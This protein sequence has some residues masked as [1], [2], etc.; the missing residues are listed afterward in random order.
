MYRFV[1]DQFSADQIND[2]YAVTSEDVEMKLAQVDGHYIA[3]VWNCILM[4]RI[5]FLVSLVVRKHLR[6]VSSDF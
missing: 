1:L 3:T 6:S 2:G 5:D 4:L